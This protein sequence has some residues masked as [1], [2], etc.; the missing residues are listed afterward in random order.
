MTDQELKDLVASLAIAQQETDKKFQETSRQFQETSKK[1]LETDAQ[2]KKLGKFIGNIG[3]NQGDIAEEFFYRSFKKNPVLN[4]IH[5]DNVTRHL[6]NCVNGIEDE[7]D[8]VLINGDMVAIIE[9]KAKAHANDLE[10]LVNK[11]VVNFP[12]LFSM[13]ADY[14][15]YAGVATLVTNNELIEKAR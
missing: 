7:Y 12:L 1:F 2:L 5:F 14:H 9:V 3:N 10:K 15:L 4:D 8:I 13:Y 6:K 11:K